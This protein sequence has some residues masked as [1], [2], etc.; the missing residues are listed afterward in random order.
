MNENSFS[1]KERKKSKMKEFYQWEVDDEDNEERH[2]IHEWSQN[3]IKKM[4]GLRKSYMNFL[5]YSFNLSTLKSFIE[6]FNF[7]VILQNAIAIL[8]VWLF[9]KYNIYF[10]FHIGLF[11]SPIVFP[12][13]FS[14]NTDFQRR[15]KVLDD[16][17]NCKSSAMVLFFCMREWREAAG[18]DETWLKN[19]KRK[20]NSMMFFLREYLLTSKTKRRDIIARLMYEDFSDVSQLIEKVRA[21]KLP[22]NPS[23]ISRSVHLLNMFTLSFERLRVIREYRSPRSIRSFNKVFIFILP[24]ILSPYFVYLGRLGV[25]EI[26]IGE[27][28]PYYI[29][30]LVATV[31]GALQGVQDKLDDP[32]D[33]MSEDD[34]NLD[35]IDEWTFNSLQCAAERNYYTIGRF[36]VNANV[37]KTTSD[38]MRSVSIVQM[39]HNLEQEEKSDSEQD[40]P[41]SARSPFTKRKTAKSVFRRSTK[42]KRNPVNRSQTHS[43]A[44][45]SR[46]QRS[47]FSSSTSQNFAESHPY[48]EALENMSGVTRFERK[49]TVRKAVFRQASQDVHPTQNVEFGEV[50]QKSISENSLNTLIRKGSNVALTEHKI[51]SVSFLP[52]PQLY[53]YD[54]PS[55]DLK[56]DSESRLPLLNKKTSKEENINKNENIFEMKTPLKTN[57]NR[58]HQTLVESESESENEDENLSE[59]VVVNKQNE[60][61][62]EEDGVFS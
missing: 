36:H 62:E 11:V 27:W 17:A 5:V 24:I 21:S 40:V 53:T 52:E 38:K 9:D 12:L 48:A 25:Q 60:K 44:D 30:I 37:E 33:G 20:L 42:R 15:E 4:H 57:G 7:M 47:R 35:T 46:D 3:R 31:F 43:G 8:A 58:F 32:F 61:R 34:I 51:G 6:N 18:L 28:G 56:K 1:F 19:I 2:I 59:I 50:K 13:A 54:Q 14:I 41:N 26:S 55:P 45:Q 39:L 10:N 22:A 49:H 16:L 23:I 29:A